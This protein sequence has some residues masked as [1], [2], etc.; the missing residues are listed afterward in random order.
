MNAMRRGGGIAA[1]LAGALAVP[2]CGAA[3]RRETATVPAG[4]SAVTTPAARPEIQVNRSYWYA[5]LKVTL[6]TA[7]LSSASSGGTRSPVLSIGATF[8]NLSPDRD[9]EPAAEFI[10]TS[11]SDS[12]DELSDEETELPRIPAQRSRTG[13]IAIEVDDR[14]ELSEAVLTIG[15]PRSRQAVV[16]LARQDGW[17]SLEPRPI[18]VRGRVYPEGRTDVFATVTGGEVRADDPA[19]LAEAPADQEY[20]LV[21]FTAT[22]NGP[23]GMTYVF[24]R[25]LSLVLPDGT[26][27]GNA[28]SCSRAQVYVQPHATSA[29]KGPACFAVP[30]PATG[31][32]RFVWDNKDSQGLRFSI[33]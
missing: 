30:A 24:D 22:N 31:A 14:F 26:K 6:G 18:S 8:Q 5:G 27:A 29:P 12:Y 20:V 25:D 1:V 13:V 33:G 9:A 21:S 11:G 17:I 16:P 28:G 10:V 19:N 15:E 4:S 32:Y 23:A 7:R 3:G 2:G